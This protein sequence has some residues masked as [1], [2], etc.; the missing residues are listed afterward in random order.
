MFSL[1][2]TTV[3]P[4]MVVFSAK[5]TYRYPWV[6]CLLL[7]SGRN[8]SWTPCSCYGTIV[9]KHMYVR[10]EDERTYS[11]CRLWSNMRTAEYFCEFNSSGAQLCKY[12]Y[13]QLKYVIFCFAKSGYIFI[14]CYFIFFETVYWFIEHRFDLLYWLH[15]LTTSSLFCWHF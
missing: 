9:M 3:Y 5:H 8:P 10:W 15:R 6:P 12:E 1:I 4:P 7:K 11:I 14:V 2:N 13:F